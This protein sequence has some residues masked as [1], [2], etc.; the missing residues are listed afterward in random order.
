[1]HA[2]VV[3]P[4]CPK[5]GLILFLEAVLHTT[6]P[7]TNCRHARRSL[8]YRYS[9][10]YLQYSGPQ[11]ELYPTSQPQWVAG[12]TA[13]QRAVLGVAGNGRPELDN[14]GQLIEPP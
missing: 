7:W 12:L 10:P 4:A 1:M 5:G 8:M 3:N 14:A 13:A 2:P 9:P 11:N 6:L